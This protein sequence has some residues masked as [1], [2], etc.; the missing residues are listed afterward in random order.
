MRTSQ[1]AT[2]GFLV[3]DA[4]HVLRGVNRHWDAL[5]GLGA[6]EAERKRFS[7]S[8]AEGG[9][10][11][12]TIGDQDAALV[13]ESQRQVLKDYVGMY[14]SS[15][16]LIVH[17]IDGR[18][19]K[20]ELALKL[21]GVFPGSD[22]A[23]LAYVKDL[24]PRMRRF[25][26]ALAARGFGKDKQGG[27]LDAASEFRKAYAARGKERGAARSERMAR[28]VVFKAL[29]TQTSYF[30]RVGREALRNSVARADFDRVKLPGGKPN[31]A[32]AP[33]TQSA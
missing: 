8:I 5:R 31:A 25:S 4:E 13:L 22:V 29:R 23:L 32:P 17:T 3:A 15:A 14:R 27:L 10:I 28:E 6:T 21:R 12:A 30:R 7:Q 24:E 26:A 18:D 1:H 19:A 2:F 20:A 11:L 16:S 33:V 9:R